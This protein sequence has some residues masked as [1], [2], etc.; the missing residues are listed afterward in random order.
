MYVQGT[1][2]LGQPAQLEVGYSWTIPPGWKELTTGNIN[3]VITTTNDIWLQRVD[4]NCSLS[5]NLK[6]EGTI[7]HKC[8]SAGLSAAATIT[9]NGAKPVVTV[10]PQVGYQ[11]A[12]YCNTDPVTFY[13]TLNYALGCIQ[14]YEWHHPAS[15][16][17]VSQTANSITLRP[18]GSPDDANDI[19]A[20]VKFT[21]G[22]S[23]QSGNYKPAFN[24]PS[25]NGSGPVCYQG[26]TFNVNY[27]PPG[28]TVTWTASPSNLFSPAS[29]SFTSTAGIN[30]FVIKTATSYFNG[31]ATI[32]INVVN[33]SCNL[34]FPS[35]PTSVWAGPPTQPGPISGEINPST[36][37]IY[38]YVSAYS[39]TGATY[40]DWI[41]PYCTTGCTTPW[42][43]FGG[44]ISGPV[45]TLTPNFKVGS[46]SGNLQ[47]AGYNG[48]GGSSFSKLRVFPVSGGGGVIQLI[49]IYPNP[50]NHEVKVKWKEKDKLK[51]YDVLL[52]D[53]DSNK[54]YEASQQLDDEITIPVKQLPNGSYYLILTQGDLRGAQVL[55]V[56]HN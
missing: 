48:C 20:K 41:T 7:N 6:V 3:S 51:P 28:S 18:S 17:P 47:V 50:G 1:G 21:C 27:A 38:Q 11:G 23:I 32:S 14:E 13:A 55:L 2:G 52:Y 35:A 44:T 34:N 30:S 10:G 53:K 31:S 36:G 40:Y 15:W 39:S 42:S 25:I 29:G 49:S 37:G 43:W 22:T 19:Y 45:N 26:T 33:T 8:G 9:L 12:S 56:D 46:S 5:G 24:K 4:G 16:S 54:V